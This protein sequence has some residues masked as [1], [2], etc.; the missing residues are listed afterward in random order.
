V[1]QGLV[2]VLWG[3]VRL[4]ERLGRRVL[5]RLLVLGRLVLGRLVLGRLVLGRLVLGRLLRR[6]LQ[7]KRRSKARSLLWGRVPK[8]SALRLGD[9]RSSMR[10]PVV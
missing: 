7:L 3:L 4:L 6:L 10:S 9:K 2:R 8:P 1:A 5:V